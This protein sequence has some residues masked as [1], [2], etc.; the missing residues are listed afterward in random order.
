MNR[1]RPQHGMTI[2]EV[3]VATMVLAVVSF[4]IFSAFAIGLRAT[5]LAGGMQTA[6]GLA[7]ESLARV[8]AS[9]CGSSFRLASSQPV[10][11]VQDPRLA[12]FERAVTVRP[13]GRPGL[14]E[15]TATVTWTQERGRRNVTLTT[16]RYLSTAC[17]FVGQ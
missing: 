5:A 16:W 14:Y 9:P 12:R 8:A 2:L 3:L 13:A 7:E 17:A 15:I 11:G 10:E 4:V 1:E 6:T